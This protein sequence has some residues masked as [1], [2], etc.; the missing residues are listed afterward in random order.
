MPSKQEVIAK[1][2]ELLKADDAEQV[3]AAMP[4]IEAEY[5]QATEERRK[6]KLEA[7]I[8]GGG[9]EADFKPGREGED[10][11]FAELINLYKASLVQP[12]EEKE[13]EPVAEPIVEAAPEQPTTPLTKKEVIAKLE[14]LQKSEDVEHIAA[15]LESLDA[16]YHKA[17]GD[18]E[19]AQ[20]E[21]FKADGGEEGDFQPI[22][23][24]DDN[25]YKELQNIVNERLEK[26]EKAQANA[27]EESIKVRR[28]I[29]E[30]LKRLTKEESGIA[31]AFDGFK[32]LQEKW[33]TAG[34]LPTKQYKQLQSEYSHAIDM[35]FY[36]IDIYRALKI[37]DFNK[38]LLTKKKLIA[39]MQEL[40]NDDS[41]RKMEMKVKALQ[42][43][44]TET[45]PVPN[46]HW[47]EIRDDFRKAIN[48]VYEKIQAHYDSLKEVFNQNLEAKNVLLEKAKTLTEGELDS[49]NK[50]QVKT[51]EVLELQKQ[52]R[53][54]GP[55]NKK[56]N[57]R[58]WKEF[59]AACDNFF[60]K[61]KGF[62]D[63]R[64]EE[65]N[66]H[67]DA[68]LELIKKAEALKDSNEFKKTTD[69]LVELQNQWKE[70]GSAG[71][72]DEQ[73][74]WNRFRAAC[75]HFFDAKKQYYA[76]L[77]DRLAENQKL[78]EE[79]IAKLGE[80]KPT[81]D[82]AV[83][84]DALKAVNEEWRTFGPAPRKVADELYETYKQ[85][86]DSR[87]DALRMGRQEM[88]T[89]KYKSKVDNLKSDSSGKSL[90]Y[91]K[92]NIKDQ[93][94][95]IEDSIAQ[96]ENNLS[97]FGRSKNADALKEGVIKEIEKHREDVKEL[98][99]KLKVLNRPAPK[100]EEVKT[101][102][103]DLKD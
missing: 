7:F 16:A 6:A 39:Q 93:I 47:K 88:A 53:T 66:G 9:E 27:Q 100:V 98:K 52:W 82:N 71:Q 54:I 25:R 72:K 102:T 44:W 33:R 10:S 34:A 30:E 22:K 35:F 83:D 77:D 15:E 43:E 12:E 36:T 49:H 69:A 63:S 59:R 38:N 37:H 19:H 96:L 62:Y 55:A 20:L 99:D 91:E 103:T 23:D 64:K 51:A 67:R 24:Q 87:Y 32:A 45:G 81:G 4:A 11:R 58:V 95:K 78:R 75:N 50:W 74:L 85:V 90:D 28:E 94:K 26:L 97:F 84:M 42:N 70:V 92:R 79:F 46:E 68:K 61:K 31:Q 17:S 1:L 86:L 29:I 2:E 5:A 57:E 80:W 14:G 41:V 73:K 76:T 48:E 3:A 56:D 65:F 21:A 101:E 60:A 8:A 18:L 40:K 13:P 89:M